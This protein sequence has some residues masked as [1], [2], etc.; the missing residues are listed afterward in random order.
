MQHRNTREGY[1]PGAVELLDDDFDHGLGFSAGDRVEIV[2]DHAIYPGETGEVYAVAR[3][4]GF[5]SGGYVVD[6][7]IDDTEEPH[8]FRPD[9]I[10][11]VL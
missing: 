2:E 4:K 6:V 11:D 3:G 8:R 5:Y 10:G 9:E 1:E 7:L